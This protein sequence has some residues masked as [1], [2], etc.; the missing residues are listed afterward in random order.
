MRLDGVVAASEGL[1][2]GAHSTN[3]KLPAAGN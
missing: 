3:H 2:H 1:R